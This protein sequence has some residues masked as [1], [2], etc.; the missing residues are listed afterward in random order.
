MRL[1]G[2]NLLFQG[3]AI[4]SNKSP[5]LN[6]RGNLGRT[7]VDTVSFKGNN[8][9]L[10]QELIDYLKSVKKS[11]KL[12]FEKVKKYI[13][14][15]A[16]PNAKDKNGQTPLHITARSNS[17]D[18]IEFLIKSGADA[19][20]KDKYSVSPLHEA[21]CFKANEALELLIKNGAD[22]NAKDRDGDT[23]SHIAAMKGNK[24]VLETLIRHKADIKAK[25]QNGA[26]PSD[27]AAKFEHYDVAQ[28]LRYKMQER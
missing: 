5:N 10:D 9:R 28:Y 14:D 13:T 8:E 24:E 6:F 25:N 26:T 23:P 1:L 22:V 18:I 21:A 7:Q 3:K 20:I 17:T 12:D 19:N 4:Q 27:T 16:D 15:G 11:E 2:I